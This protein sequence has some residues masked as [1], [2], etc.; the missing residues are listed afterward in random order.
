[1]T[2]TRII[3]PEHKRDHYTDV[4]CSSCAKP[5]TPVFTKP[6]QDPDIWDSLQ[7]DT[8]LKIKL[9]GGYGMFIDTGFMTPEEADQL[10]ILLCEACTKTLCQTFPYFEKAVSVAR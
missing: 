7:A 8:A 5:L 2:Y 10:V 9:Q 4:K 6:G 1:M 3:R